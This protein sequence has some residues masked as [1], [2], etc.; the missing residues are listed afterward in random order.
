MIAGLLIGR[1]TDVG[2]VIN[3]AG[4]LGQDWMYLTRLM[5]ANAQGAIGQEMYEID[6][7]AKR[8]VQELN[9]TMLWCLFNS[10]GAAI[11]VNIFA[12][13]LVALP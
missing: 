9:Q 13:V 12:R 7:R 5:P 2:A 6:L 8:K 3:L 1:E 4:D 10:T 11:T